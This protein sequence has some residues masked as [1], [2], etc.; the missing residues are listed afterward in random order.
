MKQFKLNFNFLIANFVSRFNIGLLRKLRF[1]K[2][3]KEIIFMRLL[4][5]LYKYGII[6]TFRIHS[7]YIAVYFKFIHGQPIG[8]LSLVS[9]PG[10]RCY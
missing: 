2:L 6:R 3:P 4:L 5:I 7:T 8:K 1:I 10:K 9:R